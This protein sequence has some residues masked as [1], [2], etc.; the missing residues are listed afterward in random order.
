MPELYKARWRHIGDAIAV[1]DLFQLYCRDEVSF[2]AMMFDAATHRSAL[3]GKPAPLEYE[4][5]LVRAVRSNLH[6]LNTGI[7]V[8]TAVL[9]NLKRMEGSHSL[10]HW[11]ALKEMITL[12]GGLS[13]FTGDHIM[14]TKVVW[15][16]VALPGPL[17]GFDFAPDLEDGLRDLNDLLRSRQKAIVDLLPTSE[18][19][20]D[21]LSD[22]R[23]IKVFRSSKLRNL[24]QTPSSEHPT[25]RNCRLAVILFLASA[26]MLHGDFDPATDSCI[27]AISQHLE[28]A[29]DDASVSP[30]HL[31]WFVVRLSVSA[32]IGER[33]AQIWTGVIR[34]LTALHRLK[35]L[36]QDNAERLL[37]ASLEI[38]ESCG[39]IP[40]TY[41]L[42]GE[43]QIDAEPLRQD[44]H[45]RSVPAECFC[46]LLWFTAPP[47]E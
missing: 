6:T 19:E 26:L 24:L 2:Q 30:V 47:N 22:L 36:V 4:N 18:E 38:P 35:P 16:F 5:R 12:H 17:T 37:F 41:G 7:I 28:E 10:S 14:F 29:R 13:S 45:D 23:R 3:Q 46:E 32:S 40:A 27:E 11:V 34:I 43:L 31:L 33:Y 42:D 39:E 25:E 1:R 20:M 8:A 21:R 9:C 44:V 15:T